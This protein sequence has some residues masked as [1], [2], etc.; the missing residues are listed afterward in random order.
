MESH[1]AGSTSQNFLPMF[2]KTALE[3]NLNCDTTAVKQS[4]SPWQLC[5]THMHSS[6]GVVDKNVKSAILFTCDSLK[7]I[8]NFFFIGRV[9]DDWHTVSTPFFNLQL[10]K[11]C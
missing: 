4:H 3:K 1:M 5:G 7:K 8:L 11:T 9:A 2:S 10:D 6:I